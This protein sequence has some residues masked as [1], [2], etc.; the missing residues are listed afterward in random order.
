MAI[1]LT[2]ALS[3]DI[4]ATEGKTLSYFFCD[5][6]FEKRKTATSITRGLLL[7]LVQQRPQ[8]LGYLLPKYKER[9]DEL[10]QSFDALWTIFLDAAADQKTGQKFCIID[11]LDECEQES[12]RVLLGQLRTSFL[13]QGAPQ[14]IK[15]LVT[16]RPYD[17]IHEYMDDFAKKDL[18]SYP[19]ARQDVHRCIE[20]RVEGLTERKKY[21]PKV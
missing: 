20:V 16:S 21:T 18:A 15:I 5:S 17:E 2:E 19:E 14:G 8:L 12:Q 9:G 13:G 10:F 4:A 1:Y 7:Q 3:S 6:S 11:A